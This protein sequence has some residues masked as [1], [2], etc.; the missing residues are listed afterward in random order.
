MHFLPLLSH[1][2]FVENILSLRADTDTSARCPGK[3]K[4]RASSFKYQFLKVIL[5]VTELIGAL[6]PQRR[7]ERRQAKRVSRRDFQYYGSKLSPHFR[8]LGAKG[9]RA[10]IRLFLDFS[11]AIIYSLTLSF[12][13]WRNRWIRG[14]GHATLRRKVRSSRDLQCQIPP[15]FVG[16]DSH[17]GCTARKTRAFPDT[18]PDA[19]VL[20][21]VRMHAR[22]LV[23]GAQWTMPSRYRAR[24]FRRP[25]RRRLRWRLGFKVP[26]EPSPFF[27]GWSRPARRRVLE[28]RTIEACAPV[29]QREAVSSMPDG[30]HGRRIRASSKAA[31]VPN[32]NTISRWFFN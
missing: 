27:G 21:R 13:K 25:L 15:R 7:R 29:D 1:E 16:S 22:C 4:P 12:L 10:D 18:P 6:R 19:R 28:S 17:V 8:T 26:S 23:Y 11:S 2:V 32:R 24:R 5:E 31:R 20:G 3:W 9:N 14:D 30:M